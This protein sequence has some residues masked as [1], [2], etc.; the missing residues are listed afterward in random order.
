M[1]S[2]I[3]A[4]WIKLRHRW[5]PR[6]L[7]LLT[8]I[9]V[10]LLFWGTGTQRDLRHDLIMPNGWISSLSFASLVAPFL[11]PVLGG[12]W[13]GNEYGWGTIRLVLSR[14]PNRAEFVLS[15]LLIL[16]VFV[17]VALL[18]TAVF[19]SLFALTVSLLTGNAA[20]ASHAFGGT[21]LGVLVKEFLASWYVLLFYLAISYAAGTL[22][23]SGAVGIGVGIG[24]TLADLIVGGIF[25][26]LGGT[27][28]KIA[29]HFPGEYT[30]T[31][32]ELVAKGTLS[33]HA[34][35]LPSNSP[36]ATEC[37]I[38]LALYILVPVVIALGLVGLRDVTS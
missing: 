8:L 14:R 25:Q 28:E 13:A 6:V 16:A 29:L 31:L 24:V 5:M 2:L 37:V 34:V 26:G 32:P 20:F 38:A 4:E 12:S 35:G 23:R 9:A 21:F 15:G 11:W 3:A 22:F 19:S 27:W 18:V 33:R 36:G 10:A 1:T 7:V 17:A 30:R